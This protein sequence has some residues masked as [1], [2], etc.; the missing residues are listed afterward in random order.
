M[1]GEVFLTY[2]AS[3]ID[4]TILVMSIGIFG[5]ILSF[6]RESS[7]SFDIVDRSTVFTNFICENVLS[8]SHEV[9]GVAPNIC[10]SLLTLGYRSASILERVVWREDGAG[11]PLFSATI[12]ELNHNS[13]S[14]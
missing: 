12:H 10:S 11:S 9:T 8:A 6:K 1:K 14:V 5:C 13:S 3:N 4:S 7:R 2:L